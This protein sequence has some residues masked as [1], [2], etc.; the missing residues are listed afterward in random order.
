MIQGKD[1]GEF[2]R[3]VEIAAV[4]SFIEVI[5]FVSKFNYPKT[6]KPQNPNNLN[7]FKIINNI[8][9]KRNPN[10]LNVETNEVT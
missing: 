6:P 3:V 10:K 5:Y 7:L 9:M 1:G 4:Q 2:Y 8:L